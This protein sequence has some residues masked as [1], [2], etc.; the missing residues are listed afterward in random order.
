LHAR[1]TTALKALIVVPLALAVGCAGERAA[2]EQAA[3]EGSMEMADTAPAMMDTAG[4]MA[5][6]MM[7]D[8]SQA[9][10]D[11]SMM[12]MAADRYTL[13]VNNP[14]PHTMIVYQEKSGDGEAVE[15]GRVEANTTAEFEIV[16]PESRTIELRSTDV[17]ET[18]TVTGAVT[19][20][21]MEPATWTIEM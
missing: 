1:T 15:L 6:T 2:E 21:E 9:M 10:A 4:E 18:H 8:T 14:M 13:T 11:T 20:T 3:D 7:A 16:T 5:D 12:E 19:L 17:D